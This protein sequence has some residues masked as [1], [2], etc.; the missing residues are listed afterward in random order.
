[1]S[2]ELAVASTR[3][4]GK[5]ECPILLLWST[6][7]EFA[8]ANSYLPPKKPV[9]GQNE[10]AVWVAVLNSILWRTG[11]E[12]NVVD[13]K[14]VSDDLRCKLYEQLSTEHVECYPNSLAFSPDFVS[15]WYIHSFHV[16]ASHT[17]RRTKH[18]AK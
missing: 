16:A 12:K 4:L 13:R 3:Y 1:M 7:Y 14:S 15:F 6:E 17:H 5:K 9:L 18:W 10:L 8:T 11:S 2:A